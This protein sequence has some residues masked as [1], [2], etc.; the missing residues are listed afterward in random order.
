MK[1][2]SLKTLFLFSLP[3]FS[4]SLI[5][6][7]DLI[8]ISC[9]TKEE[10]KLYVLGVNPAAT[11]NLNSPALSHYKKFLTNLSSSSSPTIY[12]LHGSEQLIKN[13]SL[14]K[15][16]VFN[17]NLCGLS[18]NNASQCNFKSGRVE[19]RASPDTIAELEHLNNSAFDCFK[20]DFIDDL[21]KEHHSLKKWL[22]TKV[23]PFFKNH[24]M[25]DPFFS[26]AENKKNLLSLKRLSS[27]KLLKTF[28]IPLSKNILP[29]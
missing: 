21:A 3:L 26:G 24:G 9:F 14:G 29:F 22:T 28:R 13:I 4:V 12:I 5:K 19:Y 15:T 27:P 8:S 10:K 6:G 11:N 20:P 7:S 23:I 25:P 1:K 16:A 17:D 18:L 2:S